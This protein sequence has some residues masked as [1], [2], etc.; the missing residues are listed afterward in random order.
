MTPPALEGKAVV[1]TGAG[2]GLGRA[3][4]RHLAGSGASVV[5]NDLDAAAVDAVVEEIHGG[6]GTAVA[7][8]HSVAAAQ[9]AEAIVATCCETFGRI[10]GLVNNAGVLS[11]APAWD[12]AEAQVRAMVEVNL[13]GSILCGHAAIRAMRRR[14]GGGSI[15]N[16]TSGTHLGQP[17]LAVYGATKGAVASL[18]YGWALD[19]QGSGIR[20][21]A[22]S[23]LAVTAMKLPPYEGHARPEDV[24]AVVEYLL[25]DLSSPMTGQIVRRARSELGLIHH[26]AIGRMLRGTWTVDTIA[27]AFEREL[28]DDLQPIGFGTHRVGALRA[29]EH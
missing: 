17:G 14:P 22:V 10:D 5:V 21:N 2:R 11:E 9:D 27:G 18:T 6:G 16:V 24:A 19:L 13:V 23:P 3:Y 26:P 1:V 20:V 12:T 4:A 29:R 8:V 25:S 7:S 28:A 15:V